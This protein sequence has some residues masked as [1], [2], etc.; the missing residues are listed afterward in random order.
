MKSG[1]LYILS[2]G[3]IRPEKNHIE[4]LRI[5]AEVK[6]T[7]EMDEKLKFLKC[8]LLIAGGCRNEEDRKRVEFLENYAKENYDLRRN[9]DI[10]WHLNV[11]FKKLLELLGVNFYYNIKDFL[12]KLF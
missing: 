10:E 7:L 12:N 4:Q 8:K 2:V 11:P 6:K 3:Q 1:V 9:E 5:F